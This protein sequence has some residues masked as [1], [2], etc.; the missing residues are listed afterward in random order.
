[1]RSGEPSR[2]D[3]GEYLA[4]LASRVSGI[5]FPGTPAC[6]VAV[7]SPSPRFEIEEA[8]PCGIAAVELF[9]LAA[10]GGGPDKATLSLRPAGG[11]RFALSLEGEMLPEAEGFSKE[12]ITALGGQLNASAAFGGSGIR[13]EFELGAGGRGRWRQ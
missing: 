5:A 2:I 10:R 9:L 4:A 11:G 1:M 13:L 12:L 8:L 7:D 6:A 3:M